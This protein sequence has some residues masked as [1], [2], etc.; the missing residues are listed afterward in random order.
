MKRGNSNTVKLLSSILVLVVLVL[1]TGSVRSDTC[2][3]T[4]KEDSKLGAPNYSGVIYTVDTTSPDAYRKM[5]ARLRE[6]LTRRGEYRQGVPILPEQTSVPDS[7]RYILLEIIVAG[8]PRG[9][10]F[11]IDVTNV[12]IVGYLVGSTRYFFMEAPARAE[13]LLFTVAA[14]QTSPT[15]RSSNYAK[16]EQNAGA[17]R[18]AIPLGLPSLADAIRTLV[19]TRPEDAR[20]HLVVIQMVSEAVRYWEIELNV[21]QAANN[22]NPSFLPDAR[23]I[24]LENNWSAL[25]L[26]I[27]TSDAFAFQRPITIGDEVAD[28]VQSAVIRGMFLM[29]FR[30]AR[31]RRDLQMPMEEVRRKRLIGPGTEILRRDLGLSIDPPPVQ[32]DDDTCKHL[33]DSRSRIMGRDGLCVEVQGF[34]YSDRNP[35]ILFAC[36]SGD[37]AKQLWNFR[38]D[39]R[40]VSFGKCLAASGVTPRSTVVIHECE[41][42]HESAVRWEMSNS[43]TLSNRASGLALHAASGSGRQL[44]LQRDISSS[45]QAWQSTNIITPVDV[46]IQ[47][48]NNRCIYY[49]GGTNTYVE[50][51]RNDYSRQKWRLYPDST[52]RPIEWLNGCL[53]LST[54]VEHPRYNFIQLGH[55]NN[56]P[57]YH[58]WIFTQGCIMNLYSSLVVDEDRD[59]PAEGW[60]K[61]APFQGGLNQI[62]KLVF[63]S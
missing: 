51:C 45:F 22:A 32:K 60:L 11:A 2:L 54:F 7:Q 15:R 25:S 63:V 5:I 1:L 40:I 3:N 56:H 49:N 21:L 16:L 48:E 6:L 18:R 35:V 43:G 10:T 42:I 36:R 19:T 61:A 52:I 62:W 38:T 58:R 17:P 23:M 14:I 20:S 53:E 24:D 46:Y 39:G 8:T 28:N 47:G 50:G 44:T 26:Q 57:E 4:V 33:A 31:P 55:C 34:N 29:L 12:Y 30:C 41:T 9:V 13:E 59:Y 27:Q 37:F